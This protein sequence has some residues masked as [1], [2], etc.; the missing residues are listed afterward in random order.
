MEF[1]SIWRSVLMVL[2]IGLVIFVHEL[3]HFIAARLCGV[4]VETFSLGFGPKLLGWRRGDTVYQLALL[5]IGGF[6]RMAGE[7]RLANEDRPAPDDL[8]AKTVG[9]RFFIYSGG[10]LMNV[11]FALLAMPLVLFLGVSF[12]APV[13]GWV[14]PGSPA[15]HARVTPGARIVSVN[16]APIA[17]F[18]FVEHEVALGASN[19]AQVVVVDPGKSET[20]TH[21]I[22]PRYRDD[23]GIYTIGVRSGADRDGAIA[24]APDS[25]ASEAGLSD[26]DRILS[27]ACEAP[28]LPLDQQL[29][30]A[31]AQGGP[32][33]LQV[34][35]EG[36]SPRTVRVTPAT[37]PR[38][39]RRML[40]VGPSADRVKDLR[41]SPLVEALGLRIGDRV[42]RINGQAVHRPL[43][44]HLG[45]LR[46]SD[47]TRVLVER[48]GAQ[49]NLEL[50]GLTRAEALELAND[51]ALEFA[52]REVAIY[53]LPNASVRGVLQDG[54]R[55]LMVNGVSV[56]GWDE[57]LPV[58]QGAAKD[59]QSLLVK[60]AR[61]SAD[62]S[63]ETRELTVSPGPATDILY[64]FAQREA[65]YTYRAS[66]ALEALQVGVQANWKFARDT[67]SMV[68]RMLQGEVS[69][70]NMG[71]IISIGVVSY[72]WSEHGVLK[73][74]FFL[75]M[76]SINLAFINV[77]PIP[78]LDGGHLFFL[79]IEKLQ[80][81][82]VS[83]RVFG[84]SQVVGLVLI[85]T[86]LVY[87]TYNDIMRWSSLLSG[88]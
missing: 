52:E 6:V 73:L 36:Q 45:L 67:W 87:V 35:R 11:V 5:P 59:D 80:G 74:L 15:W 64:G 19:P 1:D 44:L 32:V 12:S 85:L 4:R 27:V 88:S 13:V 53:L 22:T 25:A 3:G 55:I 51:I 46:G 84:Y 43:D 21:V 50:R 24:V 48:A 16:D 34:Q 20:R 58:V 47:A 61:E 41:A 2:G 69:S 39:D 78:L 57:F 26:E 31:T 70:K 86:L 14:E 9:Q 62:G 76:L 77:L 66:G 30:L 38:E 65:M 29:A 37:K 7:E 54:D 79:V 33:E 56:A 28:E 60:V 17:S 82:P 42:L 63:V 75:C 8:R 49:V 72:S 10:V 81:R 68:K 71:G 18:D 23:I 40:G 83:E